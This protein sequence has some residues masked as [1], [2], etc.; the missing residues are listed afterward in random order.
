MC[1]LGVSPVR[2]QCCPTSM[3]GRAAGGGRSALLL[4]AAPYAYYP[5]SVVPECLCVV[6]LA[7]CAADF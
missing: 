4:L 7:A 2:E 3:R 6:R 5:D 1:P